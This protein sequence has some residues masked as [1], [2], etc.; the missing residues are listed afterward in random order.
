MEMLTLEIV[1]STVQSCM[2]AER[3]GARRIELCSALKTA[4]VTP[5]I[6][7]LREVKL[8]VSLPVFVMIRPR[9]GDF[10]YSSSEIAVME[11]DIELSI[12]AGADGIVFGTLDENN[13]VDQKLLR[14]LV[15]RCKSLPVTFHRAFDVTDN[16]GDAMKAIIDSGCQRILTSGGEASC[17][18][19]KA[20]IH[21]LGEKADG[22]IIILPG[23]GVSVENIQDIF[24]PAI[25][26]YHMSARSI[27]KSSAPQKIF[28]TDYEET[29]ENKVRSVI[30]LANQFFAD[31]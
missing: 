29:D 4:G 28:E 6:G 3:G 7:L 8:N 1:A 12:E 17:I 30:S 26:E 11:R 27:F 23:G 21:R 13:R 10:V 31:K 25:L 9:E 24:H 18:A 14:S 19:G 20:E 5:S 16:L 15:Q 22:K 2:N